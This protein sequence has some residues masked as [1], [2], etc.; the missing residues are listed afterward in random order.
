MG[1]TVEVSIPLINKHHSCSCCIK[2]QPEKRFCKQWNKPTNDCGL[3]CKPKPEW[4]KPD[5]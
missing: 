1:N 3:E 4:E 5:D 2:F